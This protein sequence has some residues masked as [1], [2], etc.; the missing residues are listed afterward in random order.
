MKRS[1]TAAVLLEALSPVVA[2]HELYLESVDLAGPPNRRTV[3]VVVDL[4]DGPGGVSS[5]ALD[6]VSRAISGRLDEV[7]DVPG[8]SYLLEVTTP[9]VSR[10]LTEPRHFRRAQGRLVTVHTTEGTV[11]GRLMVA[12]DE[13]LQVQ[14]SPKQRGGR[15]PQPQSLP[16]SQVQ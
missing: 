6:E 14:P 13:G 15:A 9:G 16:W 1:D 5:D 7:E 12:D 2:A 4:R 3:T 8:G 11:A 10:P